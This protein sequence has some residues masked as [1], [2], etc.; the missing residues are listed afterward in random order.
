MSGVYSGMMVHMKVLS[1][2]FQFGSEGGLLKLLHNKSANYLYLGVLKE[3][4]C[5]RL[6]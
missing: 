4:C 6:S 1:Q 5:L 3:F 2:E